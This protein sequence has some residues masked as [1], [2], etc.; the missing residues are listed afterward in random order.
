M[1]VGNNGMQYVSNEPYNNEVAQQRAFNM[2]QRNNMMGMNQ[3]MPTSPYMGQ[4]SNQN[5]MG[6]NNMQAIYGRPVSGVEEARACMIGFDGSLYVFPDIAHGK[7]YTKQTLLDGTAEFLTY[8]LVVE[9]QPKQEEP[10]TTVKA[11]NSKYVLKKDFDKA[12]KT[13]KTE[14]QEVKKYERNASVNATDDEE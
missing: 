6:V 12:I 7:I 14:L 2:N 8:N 5:S 9:E 11:D 10:K 4:I 13:L 3:N 1:I